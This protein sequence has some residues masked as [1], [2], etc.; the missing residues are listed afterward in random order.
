MRLYYVVGSPNCRKVHAVINHLGLK[1]DNTVLE[2]RKY[3]VGNDIT[4]ADYSMIH[5]EGFKDMS[6]FD[7]KPYPHLNAYFDRMRAVAH[8]AKTAPASPQDVGRRPAAKA[9]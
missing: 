2:G 7:W 9:A 1:V 3:L 6:P 4:L 8:W 5:L